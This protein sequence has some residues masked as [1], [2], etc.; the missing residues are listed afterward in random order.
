MG[1]RGVYFG[2]FAVFCVWLFSPSGLDVF[3]SGWLAT[4]C[5]TTTLVGH[6]PVALVWVLRNVSLFFVFF[7]VVFGRAAIYSRC[8]YSKGMCFLLLAPAEHKIGW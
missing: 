6:C 3:L 4:T 7:V 5:L 8:L 2:G 1:W